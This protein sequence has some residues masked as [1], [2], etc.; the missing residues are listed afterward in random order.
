MA[1]RSLIRWHSLRLS[2][3]AAIDAQLAEC[4]PGGVLLEENLRGFVM[5]LS[6]HFQGFGRDLYSECV[7]SAVSAMPT[8]FGFMVTRQFEAK[9]ALDAGNPSYETIK[10][11]FGRFGI[12]VAV[13][14]A[15]NSGHANR[16]TQL[17]HLMA[18]RNHAAHYNDGNPKTGPATLSLADLRSW[19]ASCDAFACELDAAMHGYLAST[20][21][22]PPW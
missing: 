4:P 6:A 10:S 20:L 13:V 12:D 14:L 11:D 7:N 8:N 16:V 17:G 3:L 15:A 21:G 22:Q 5:L 18:W 1:S 9:V 2:G 19:T